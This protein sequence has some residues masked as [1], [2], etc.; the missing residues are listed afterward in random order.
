MAFDESWTGHGSNKL[1]RVTDGV[2]EKK[3]MKFKNVCTL[4]MVY[5]VLKSFSKFQEKF[6]RF[7]EG[8][9][10]FKKHPWGS[11]EVP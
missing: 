6:I 11:H 1:Y 3:Q 7:I 4:K 2:P 10:S 9:W 5:E 8:S